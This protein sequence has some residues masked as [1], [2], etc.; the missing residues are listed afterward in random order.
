MFS[1]AA[2]PPPPR[3]PVCSPCF[4]L[5]ALLCLSP[6]RSPRRASSLVRF[7][8]PRQLAAQRAR[9]P[10]YSISLASCG[11]L[12]ASASPTAYPKIRA[13]QGQVCCAGLVPRRPQHLEGAAGE[14]LRLAPEDNV[15]LL[16]L[17]TTASGEGRNCYE[18]AAG[19]RCSIR[20]RQP[21][22][23]LPPPPPLPPPCCRDK[24]KF[25]WEVRRPWCLPASPPW[26]ATALS[27]ATGR[28]MSPRVLPR[29]SFVQPP[30]TPGPASATTPTAPRRWILRSINTSLKRKTAATCA[31]AP[32]SPCSGVWAHLVICESASARAGA[33][34]LAPRTRWPPSV[35][36]AGYAHATVA[37]PTGH[38]DHSPAA[39]A[40]CTCTTPL[41]PAVP[42]CTSTSPSTQQAALASSCPVCTATTA[43][44]TPASEQIL[45]AR[46]WW[47]EW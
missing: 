13:G 35:A 38:A 8:Q 32:T 18:S 37:Q 23:R 25:Q 31:A 1:S 39:L 16:D 41:P 12:D 45:H 10:A 42:T 26:R 27:T 24:T 44:A 46:A 3:L 43:A 29:T 17:A 9:V 34:P 20:R 40:T 19:Q 47:P 6:A 22:K 14:L 36:D 7:R 11:E 2:G 5:T 4:L 15:E 33:A 21:C 30:I 28:L